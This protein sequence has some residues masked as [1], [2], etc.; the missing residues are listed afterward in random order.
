VMSAS[1]RW[2]VV[3]KMTLRSIPVMILMT[4]CYGDIVSEWSVHLMMSRVVCHDDMIMVGSDGGEVLRYGVMMPVV[5]C[6]EPLSTFTP[7]RPFTWW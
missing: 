7:A 5:L 4:T 6:C 1:S 3:L 2:E